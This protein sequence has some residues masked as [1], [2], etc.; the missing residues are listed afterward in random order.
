MHL[1]DKIEECSIWRARAFLRVQDLAAQDRSD[2]RGN[3]EPPQCRPGKSA[4]DSD[5]RSPY[6]STAETRLANPFAFLEAD[7]F[8]RQTW[9]QAFAGNDE[10]T[11]RDVD[12]HAPH[13]P[14]VRL[15]NQLRLG[16]SDDLQCP[17]RTGRGA[18]RLQINLDIQLAAVQQAGE[19][20]EQLL[21]GR[22]A[23][24]GEQNRSDQNA[25]HEG[26]DANLPPPPARRVAG[27]VGRGVK[28]EF[29]LKRERRSCA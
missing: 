16:I 3:I 1:S 11:A 28:I 2:V 24:C 6:S 7:A 29:R 20:V 9:P 10:L 21:R 12:I 27:G 14:F 25:A 13:T 15:G 23:N 18:S 26:R 17:L 19:L 5:D 8:N 22:R 4:E